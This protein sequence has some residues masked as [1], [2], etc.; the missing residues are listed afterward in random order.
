MS[1]ELF[2]CSTSRLPCAAC[3]SFT[4]NSRSRNKRVRRGPA[5]LAL[6]P[7]RFNAIRSLVT[8]KGNSSGLEMCVKKRSSPSPHCVSSLVQGW[9]AK[10]IH[11]VTQSQHEAPALRTIVE[12][13]YVG[14]VQRGEHKVDPALSRRPA[15]L[16]FAVRTAIKHR[17]RWTLGVHKIGLD[18]NEL[19]AKGRKGRPQVLLHLA[20]AHRWLSS[21][22]HPLIPDP[23]ISE[24]RCI[25]IEKVDL[26]GRIRFPAL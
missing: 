8:L 5:D 9:H 16:E 15:N 12:S 25:L 2:I 24:F 11:C 7:R 6:K 4:Q 13:E 3:R 22:I 21:P 26:H 10:V 1:L 17:P 23:S 19:E 20:C 14:R 18:L